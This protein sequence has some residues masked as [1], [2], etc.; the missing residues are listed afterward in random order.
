MTEQPRDRRVRLDLFGGPVLSGA[1]GPCE[2]TLHQQALLTLVFAHGPGGINRPRVGR[3]IWG[4][5]DS[6]RVRQRIRQLLH[7]THARAGLNV[8]ASEGDMLRPAL[9]AVDC[10]LHVFERLLKRGSLA[11]AGGLLGKGFAARLPRSPTDA[12]EAWLDGKRVRLLEDLRRS[13]ARRWDE[14][15]EAGLWGEA[16]DSAEAL[17]MH[18]PSDLSV[19]C[20]L[21][22][23]R[24]RTGSL[25]SAEA[26][27]GHFR[28]SNEGGDM[29]EELLALMERVRRLR[30]APPMRPAEAEPKAPLVGRAEELARVRSMFGEVRQ[31]RFQF[32]LITGEGG[33]GKTRVLEELKREAV[34]EGFRCLHARPAEPEQRIPLN[35]LADALA[36][37]D[38]AG[39]L[40]GLGAPWR[41]VIAS[42]LPVD[43]D[44]P[45][46]DIPP[47]QEARL[48]RRLMDALYML[49][50]QVAA[51][52]PTL[53]FIDDLQWADATTVTALQFIQRRW[54]QGP[55]GIVTAARPDLL[56]RSDPGKRYLEHHDGLAVDQIELKELSHDD[57]R[58]L[59]GHLLGPEMDDLA[60]ERLC[61]L[62]GMHPLY[63][64]ELAKDLGAG[65][66]R[67]PSLPAD[68]VA[69][70][71]SLQEIFRSRVRLL[72]SMA[73]KVAG[74][75]A[76]RAKP[77]RLVDIA[78]LTG[79]PPEHCADCADEL[80]SLRLVDP[81]TDKLR[82]THE[83]FRSALYQHFSEARRAVLHRAIAEHLSSR[84]DEGTSGE[85][86]MHYARA[87]EREAA[88]QHGWNAGTS[89]LDHGA[90][91]EAAYFFELVVNN[92]DDFGRRAEA[93]AELARALHLNRAI[94]RANPLL[95]LAA[96]RLRQSG[97]PRRALRMDIRRVEGLAEAGSAPVGDLLDRL[98][99]IKEEASE[100]GDWE[101]LA[102]ALD[103][104]LRFAH[105][106]GD[107]PRAGTLLRELKLIQERGNAEAVVVA[108]CALCLG[109]FFGDPTAALSA[110]EAGIRATRREG[111]P[112]SYRLRALNR[113]I[114]VLYH[115]GR[116][117]ESNSVE[118]LAEARDLARTSGDLVERFSLDSNVAAELMDAGYLDHAEVMFQTAAKLMGRADMTFSRI[119]HACNR[120]ELALAQG[121]FAQARRAFLAADGF[122][123][124]TV[125]DYTKDFVNA[126]VGLSAFEL[127]DLG[128]ARKRE[129]ELRPPPARYYYDPS[130]ILRFRT[131]L[132]E[133]RGE[134]QLALRLLESAAHDLDGR[135]ML[136]AL[137]V[138]IIQVEVLLRERD[139]AAMA[140]AE[141]ALRTAMTMG[142]EPRIL[143][144]RGLLA[145]GK[146]RLG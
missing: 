73:I 102:L 15:S 32:A 117:R 26:V 76:V 44:E 141:E 122:L 1:D 108:E 63:L 109:V 36:G 94:G 16:R 126:G 135:M 12:F 21:I 85:L 146:R 60:A 136:A 57:A 41:S 139:P 113:A 118:I 20:R 145:R 91:A 49:M 40:R 10:D 27:F 13:A 78:E 19:V 47:I 131:R 82:I 43:D 116:M 125:P 33:I 28:D 50:E 70:P 11:E 48:S 143:E 61:E 96:A 37:V 129:E 98:G 111:Q 65:R 87:G 133:R 45:M 77:M 105:L 30:A 55:L 130:M 103:T 71:V 132:L 58:R 39:H 134:S 92:E 89:A 67:L 31:G 95:E 54:E 80:I 51:E 114:I 64:T 83:L 137:K 18:F 124:P 25:A 42:L 100:M 110:A 112:H 68:E 97:N 120:G 69:I 119:N 90:V 56:M 121:L 104:E 75:L 72:S 7:R 9:P 59:V 14:T 46:E 88:A 24:A 3:L 99:S 23:S 66:L 74:L 81:Q 35:P 34:L 115:Q 38:L 128:E 29:P 140:L 93:T 107:L 4:E 127:G 62:A 22:E 2:L 6:P 142:V 84:P 8:L 5:D 144:C 138:K 86:A 52:E 123:G 53:L 106:A 17:Y 79:I 101:G